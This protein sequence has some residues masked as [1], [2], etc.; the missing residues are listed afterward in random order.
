MGLNVGTLVQPYEMVE[1]DCNEPVMGRTCE[2][3]PIANQCIGIVLTITT[4][5]DPDDS[6]LST[7]RVRWVQTCPNHRN[8]ADNGA[9][10]HFLDALWEIGQLY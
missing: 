10:L 3:S 7:A 8:N 9:K 1:I 5:D 6:D 2:I 4:T